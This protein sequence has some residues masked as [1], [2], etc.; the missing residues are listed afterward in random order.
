[1]IIQDKNTATGE[2]SYFEDNSPSYLRKAIRILPGDK[3]LVRAR[4][5]EAAGSYERAIRDGLSVTQVCNWPR[6]FSIRTCVFPN[7]IWF[8]RSCRSG[9][10]KC[11]PKNGRVSA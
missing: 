5:D 2:L 4:A 6:P 9:F 1:M 7:S 10:P 8:S 3:A 11:G